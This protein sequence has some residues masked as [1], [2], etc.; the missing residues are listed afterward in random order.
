MTFASTFA[1]HIFGSSFETT[2]SSKTMITRTGLATC[3]ALCFLL[4][5]DWT[6][7]NSQLSNLSQQRVHQVESALKSTKFESTTN[8]ICTRCHRGFDSPV[9]PGR[10]D[11]AFRFLSLTEAVMKIDSV[12]PGTLTRYAAN[13]GAKDGKTMGDEVYELFNKHHFAGIAVEADARWNEQLRAVLPAENISKVLDFVT[14]T[15]CVSLLNDAH[16]PFNFDALK[17]DIDSYDAPV[18]LACLQGFRPKLIFAEVNPWVPPPFMY[19][20]MWGAP[21]AAAGTTVGDARNRDKGIGASLA[22]FDSKLQRIGYKLVQMRGYHATGETGVDAMWVLNE[23]DVFGT[24]P[25]DP[26]S[27]WHSWESVAGQ[28]YLEMHK[29]I[30]SGQDKY[31]V[32][33]R[34]WFHSWLESNCTNQDIL[35]HEIWETMS[36]HSAH[37]GQSRRGIILDTL[38]SP[39]DSR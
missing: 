15:N 16:L 29:D 4:V 35:L 24:Y 11:E 14:P 37:I 32:D 36:N 27:I 6:W 39:C 20:L 25:R 28:R 18:L 5:I 3:L 19:S 34:R 1:G 9:P 21:T 26:V 38:V 10:V 8:S 33:A 17:I 31:I 22:F 2:R 7:S 30:G 12:Y 23:L 13:L